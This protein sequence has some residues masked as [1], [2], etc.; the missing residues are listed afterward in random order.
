MSR[1]FV[2]P[3]LAVAF[4][5]APAFAP[6]AL[7]GLSAP[8]QAATKIYRKKHITGTKR[9]TARATTVKSSKSNTS[10][11]MGGA[12]GH[13]VLRATTVKSSK[14]NTSD[15]INLNSSKSNRY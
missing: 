14:S 4:L 8:A 6:A 5:A 12:G 1:T 3:F 13:G 11:R 7:P 15:R 2:I 9:G 10:D